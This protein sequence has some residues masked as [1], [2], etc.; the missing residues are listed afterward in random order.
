MQQ[1]NKKKIIYPLLAFAFTSLLALYLVYFV[2]QSQVKYTVSLVDKLALQQ[3]ENLQQTVESDLQFIGAGANFFHATQA[4]D[5]HRFPIFADEIVSS[6]KT[7]IALQWMPRVEHD[8]I[9]DHIAKVKQTYPFY[10][11]YTVPKDGPKTLGYIMPNQEAIYPASDVYPRNPDNF[12]A[13]GY[14][15]SRLR[16]QLVLDSIAKTGHPNVSD[17]IRLLQDGLDRNLAKTGLLV[18]HP[19]FDADHSEKL[20]GVVIGVIR[21]T[22]Y[23][24]SIVNKTAT[25]QELLVKVTDLGFDAEDDPLLYQSEGWLETTG[26]EVT[27]MVTLPNRGWQV[28]FK[29]DK[30]ATDNEQYVLIGIALAGLVIASLSSYIVLLLVRDQEHLEALLDIRTQELQFLVD[31]DSL[32]GIYNRRAF[33]R[34]LTDKVSQQTCFSLAVFDVDRFK[35]INDH[36]GHVAGDEM[37]RHVVAVVQKHLNKGDVFV[38]MGGDEFCII[39]QL[40]EREDLV[41]CLE[42]IGQ[43]VANSHYEFDGKLIQCSLSIGAAIRRT[44]NEEDIMQASDAQLYKSK[45]AGR[46]R[47]SIAE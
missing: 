28:D 17:K 42:R 23:F 4:E 40:V 10:Q 43:A 47:V 38:R 18:Y 29:L 34:Y 45:Q 41:R 32:T 36:Y 7:L 24:E 22:L 26:I 25:E 9:A 33:N 37:L 6:S 21:S 11:L 19:V 30:K 12:K 15:S 39:S 20:L 13:L 8:Q 46:N 3:A 27:K 44:E 5:W 35:L 16:F 31:H 14:Y 2:Y 1:L